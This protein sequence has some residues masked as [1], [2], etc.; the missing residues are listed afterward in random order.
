MSIVMTA[1][2]GRCPCGFIS[3]VC[4]ILIYKELLMANNWFVHEKNQFACELIC[5]TKFLLYLLFLRDAKNYI[6]SSTSNCA[7]KILK[8]IVSG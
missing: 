3:I 5:K 4:N 8:N 1:K 7:V 6:A 2:L